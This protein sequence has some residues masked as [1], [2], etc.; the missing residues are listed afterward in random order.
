MW[1]DGRWLWSK[2]QMLTERMLTLKSF[3]ETLRYAIDITHMSK[4]RHTLPKV[5]LKDKQERTGEWTV[6]LIYVLQYSGTKITLCMH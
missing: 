5:M 3:I 2:I 1:N 4:T 6:S